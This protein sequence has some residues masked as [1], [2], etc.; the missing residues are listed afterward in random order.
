MPGILKDLGEG[1]PEL[2]GEVG[3][4]MGG[5]RTGVSGIEMG[6]QLR[7]RVL[8]AR[9]PTGLSVLHSRLSCPLVIDMDG[10]PRGL[11]H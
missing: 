10:S 4:S 5:Q 3:D 6:E 1:L 2:P 8:P 7:T 11:E 9:D